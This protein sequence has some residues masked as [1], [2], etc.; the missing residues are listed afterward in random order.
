MPSQNNSL[1]AAIG[2]WTA[3]AIAIIFVIFPVFYVAILM[4]NGVFVWQGLTAYAVTANGP[5]APLRHIAQATILLF[6]PLYVL[7]INSI[8]EFLPT[9]KRMLARASLLF[10]LGFAALSGAHYF[11]Q[12]ST[13][14]LNLLRGTTEGLTQF[15]QANPT[16]AIGAINMLGVTLFLGLSSLL[17]APVFGNGRYETTIRLAFYANAISCLLGGV[18]FI[19]DWVMVIFVTINLGMGF[20]ILVATI[21]LARWFRQQAQP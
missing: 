17:I 19:F 7:L 14:R 12:I 16:A 1:A 15:V 10:A 13:V 18:A 21:A 6:G 11:L 4:T 5:A 20:A 9:P 3:V 2:F 8:Y